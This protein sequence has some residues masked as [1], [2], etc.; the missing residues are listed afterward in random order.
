MDCPSLR[1]AARY[2]LTV[3]LLLNVVLAKISEERKKNTRNILNILEE[4]GVLCLLDI[5]Q[6][7]FTTCECFVIFH[8][9]YYKLLPFS[10]FNVHSN[11]FHLLLT[12]H[13]ALDH[14]NGI[15][16]WRIFVPFLFLSSVASRG[17]VFD[18]LMIFT[19]FGTSKYLDTLYICT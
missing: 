5:F 1:L 4:L 17:D 14:T 15:L 18:I 3:W 6:L 8:N 13:Y 9:A 16:V 11:V 7:F 19:K 2:R 12:S 10:Y